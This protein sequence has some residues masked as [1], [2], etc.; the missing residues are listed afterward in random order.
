[1][2]RPTVAL[3]LLA[4][5]VLGGCAGGGGPET[6]SAAATP[7]AA[8]ADAAATAGYESTGTT[9][10]RL[11]ATVTAELEGDI[12]VTER[13]DVEATVPVATYRRTDGPGVAAVAASPQVQVVENPPVD[14]DPL[15]T[16]STA[17]LVAFLL[18]RSVDVERTGERTVE[19]LGETA[20][21]S[22]HGGTDADGDPV[23]VWVVRAE[24]D[25]AAVTAVG[26]APAGTDVAPFEAL[27]AAVERGTRPAAA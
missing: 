24:G 9:E 27:V 26:L 1:M 12:S 14:R 8:P 6:V 3:A 22:T 15:A 18:N 7:V 17:D 5:V 20:T 13:V 4:L 16:L 11:N 2:P 25:A 21:L 23:V 19:L 10:R